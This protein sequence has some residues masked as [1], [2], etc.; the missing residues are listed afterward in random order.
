MRDTAERILDD[1]R[2]DEPEPSLFERAQDWLGDRLAD[3]FEALAGTGGS[4]I[5]TLLA[6]GLIVG[7]VVVVVL[8][9]VRSG[10]FAPIARPPGE[11]AEVMIEL[12]RR[13]DE[14]RAEAARLESEGRWAEG[15]RC[16]YRALVAELV[17]RG[18]IAEL[19]GRTAGE[20]VRDVTASLPSAAP[21]FA[22]ATE[23]FEAA[24][25]GGADTG[26][27]E[28]ARFAELETRTLAVRVSR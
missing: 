4:G 9:L 13:P 27:A 3:L 16:R 14:W 10:G 17:A 18:A 22:A 11:A 15:L 24:W 23:L 2:Y 20:Y 1:P 12:T 8:V 25:Y 6:W 26:A 5:G 28:A 21:T 19:P 7:A